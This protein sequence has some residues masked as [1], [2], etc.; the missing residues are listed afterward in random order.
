MLRSICYNT[1]QI[2]WWGGATQLCCIY[3]NLFAHCQMLALRT[4][5]LNRSRNNICTQLGFF[6]HLSAY[7]LHTGR[8][9]PNHSAFFT[10]LTTN[11][12]SLG[13]LIYHILQLHLRTFLEHLQQSRYISAPQ[14]ALRPRCK[15]L[16][17][18]VL[19]FPPPEALN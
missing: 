3:M 4:G 11:N 7:F 17:R 5:A 2:G 6:C 13:K 15:R 19:T 8:S 14:T 9:V 1:K 10:R 16:G 18:A 12:M